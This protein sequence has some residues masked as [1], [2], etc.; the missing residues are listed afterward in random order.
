MGTKRF[1]ATLTPAKAE[2][3]AAA[4]RTSFRARVTAEKFGTRRIN[5]F[6]ADRHTD[7]QIRAMKLLTA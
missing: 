7:A 3:V 4:L 2:K 6:V 5:L 1:I